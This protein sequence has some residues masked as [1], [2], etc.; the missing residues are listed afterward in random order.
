[1]AKEITKNYTVNEK[2]AYNS[3]FVKL[4]MKQYDVGNKCWEYLP[5]VRYPMET[6]FIILFLFSKKMLLNRVVF[7]T[8]GI[9]QL[10]C[11]SNLFHDEPSHVCH[12]E[13]TCQRPPC[14]S[15]FII[16]PL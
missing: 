11:Y 14:L 8:K 9:S 4:K 13:G 5:I 10:L 7:V 16:N 3:N 2:R 15:Q 12:I 1:M 6:K